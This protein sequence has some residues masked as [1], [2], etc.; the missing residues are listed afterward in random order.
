MPTSRAVEILKGRRLQKMMTIR[1]IVAVNKENV[2][3]YYRD[4]RHSGLCLFFFSSRRRH[5]RYWRDWSSDVCSS[6]LGGILAYRS[7]GARRLIA[8]LLDLM[9]TIPTFAYLIPILALFGIGPVVGMI[10]SAIYADRKSVV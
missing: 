2:T 10:A 5:T 4:E 1:T 6:D 7:I 3:T 9:Q 8:P